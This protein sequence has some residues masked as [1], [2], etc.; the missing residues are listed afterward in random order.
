MQNETGNE[1]EPTHDAEQITDEHGHVAESMPDAAS[2]DLEV[3]SNRTNM[4]SDQTRGEEEEEEEELVVN[5]ESASDERPT[6][7]NPTVNIELPLISNENNDIVDSDRVCRRV[8]PL[9]RCCLG[10]NSDSLLPSHTS[11]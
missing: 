8:Q 4:Q 6:E 9:G 5:T 3:D 7:S 10:R 2:T 11:L 1:E